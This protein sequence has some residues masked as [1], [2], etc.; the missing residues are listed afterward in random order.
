[1]RPPLTHADRAAAR[2]YAAPLALA[3][4]VGPGR[5]EGRDRPRTWSVID[6]RVVTQAGSAAFRLLPRT[7]RPPP[8]WRRPPR[9]IATLYPPI[10]RA[11]SP[12]PRAA[13]GK[14]SGAVWSAYGSPLRLH[15]SA[16]LLRTPPAARAFSPLLASW[17]S[18][19]R[20][21]VPRS[22]LRPWRLSPARA[23]GPAPP[24]GGVRASALGAAG[25][26]SLPP[27]HC[28]PC[29]AGSLPPFVGPRWC[30]SFA[31]AGPLV[32]SSGGVGGSPACGALR[33]LLA[34]PP[35]GFLSAAPPAVAG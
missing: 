35:P 27:P 23:R 20:F 14:R 16:P 9:T 15:G 17:A 21:C 24:L 19:P 26:C 6:R 7:L 31:G 12:P 18:G 3:S 11:C 1:M 2:Q 22:V 32:G 5:P 10:V 30:W 25:L 4:T 28:Q 33:P 13:I 29:A 34:S 8:E